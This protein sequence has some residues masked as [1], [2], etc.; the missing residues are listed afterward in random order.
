[1]CNLGQYS[2]IR[3][4]HEHED[5]EPHHDRFLSFR[6]VL[7]LEASGCEHFILNSI[8]I[9][10]LFFLS[11]WALGGVPASPPKLHD[12]GSKI[13]RSVCCFFSLQEIRS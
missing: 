8:I 13:S 12:S 11:F 1:M 9:V 2:T 4:H 3:D 10:T 6:R 5:N 7:M